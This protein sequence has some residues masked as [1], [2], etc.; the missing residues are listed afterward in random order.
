MSIVQEVANNIE[1]IHNLLSQRQSETGT[2]TITDPANG[3]PLTV[4]IEIGT[5]GNLRGGQEPGY[6]YKTV[7]NG[8]RFVNGFLYLN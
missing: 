4:N 8:G 6:W 7:K 3:K 2:V 5:I 1:A